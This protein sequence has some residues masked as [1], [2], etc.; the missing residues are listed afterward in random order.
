MSTRP[1]PLEEITG[2]DAA[3][4]DLLRRNLTTLAA[5]H[6]GTPTGQLLD[7]VLAGRRPVADLHTDVGFAEIVNDGVARYRSY[8]ASLTP[9]Q[10]AALAREAE[11]LDGG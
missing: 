2:G 8:V 10:R 9:E 6:R 1:D 7:D 3:A 11:E 4:A 5:D